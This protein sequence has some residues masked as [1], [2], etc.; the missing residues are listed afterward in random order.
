MKKLN[1]IYRTADIPELDRYTVK[2][3]QI[4]SWDLMERAAEN[5]WKLFEETVDFEAPAVV[6]AGRGNNGGDG[7]A[8]ARMLYEAGRKVE[9]VCLPS[10]VSYSKDC[11]KNA[12]L[13]KQMGG[14]TTVVGHP[15]QWMPAMDAVLI[16]ALFG[17][18][19]NRPVAG[20]AAG[21]IGRIN[22]LPNEVYAVDIPSGLMGEDNAGN[23]PEAIVRADYT[24]T[25]QFPKLAFLLPENAGYVGEWRVLDIGL[26][27]EWGDADWYYTD[28]E[29][30]QGL[31]PRV[32]RF[33]HKGDNGRALLVAGSRGMMGAAILAAKAALRSGVG[34]LHCHVPAGCGDMLPI[35]VPEAITDVDCSGLCFTGVGQLGRYDAVAVG[36][37]LG[38]SA[39]TVIALGS[40]LQNWRERTI[41]D[42]D[43][44]NILAAH[45]EMLDFLHKDCILT[46]H[47]KEFERLAGKC[48]NDFDRL[49]KLITFAKQYQVCLVLKGAYSVVAVPEGKLFFNMSG[50]PGMATGGSG[51]VLTGV[52]LALA[53]NG[54][55]MPEV[56]RVGVFAHGLS[57]DLLAEEYGWR[58][59]T[60]GL[61]AEGM[62]HAW[63]EI[64][65]MTK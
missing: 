49:N 64:E 32:G 25:F 2:S 9:V 55:T 53:A 21:M 44:L 59:I 4:S 11:E 12:T 10:E 30:A 65:N 22:S 8:I 23:T 58:G 63:K 38:Q 40:L 17:S 33:A 34:V 28:L 31:L 52:L 5:W 7:Y 56:A 3:E 24:F 16:D 57:A 1:K 37:G 29:A 18:G 46:P 19:L 36:P 61:I 15:E 13:W 45:R 27:A 35:A 54:M 20:V 26:K 62:G 43:A 47:V 41:L 39:E 51:D 50:N 6:I 48:A 14:K 60:S 42:A